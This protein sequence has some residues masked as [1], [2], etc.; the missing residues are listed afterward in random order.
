MITGIRLE[1]VLHLRSWTYDAVLRGIRNPAPPAHQSEWAFFLGTERCAAALQRVAKELLN[2][3]AAAVVN[4]FTLAETRRA[5]AVRA[6]LRD[7]DATATQHGWN[8]VI[9]KAGAEPR[10]SPLVDLMDLDVLTDDATLEAMTSW[11]RSHGARVV[12]DP[13][14]AMIVPQSGDGLVIDV[15]TILREWEYDVTLATGA[16]PHVTLRRMNAQDHV[17][18]LLLHSSITHG[19][20]RGSLRDLL[21]IR[22]ALERCSGEEACELERR[23]RGHTH[24]AMLL[25]LIAATAGASPDPFRRAAAYRYAVLRRTGTEWPGRVKYSIVAAALETAACRAYPT[26]ARVV[27]NKPLQHGRTI[28]GVLR[29]WRAVRSAI[30][31]P[32]I[33]IAERD[34]MRALKQVADPSVTP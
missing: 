33:V 26:A 2:A 13:N 18:L 28:E 11:Y 22:A 7:L 6:Q 32:L 21:L 25:D 34:A 9:T 8:I 15:Q 31:R 23:V 12:P 4:A 16:V 20:R 27:L 10:S 1:A 24:A 19:T 17:W 5:M 29:L 3:E 14:G 30:I